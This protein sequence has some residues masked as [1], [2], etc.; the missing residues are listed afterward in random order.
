MESVIILDFETSGLSPDMGA[1]AIE[2]GAVRIEGGEVADS[3]Q[4]LM[5]PGVRINSFIEQYTGITNKMLSSAPPACEVMADFFS[6]IGSNGL[7]AHNASF[8]SRFLDAELSRLNMCRAADFACS[9]KIARRLYPAAPNHKLETLVR[10]KKLTTDGVYHR[11]LADAQMTGRLWCAMIDDIQ[12]QYRLGDMSFD[13]M[14]KIGNTP[15][16]AV[17]GLMRKLALGS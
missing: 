6:F 12:N 2:I 4:S 10:Y 15:K 9:L 13:T 16:A 3:F 5:N 11:A 17:P 8:D 14:C 7:V 1:R